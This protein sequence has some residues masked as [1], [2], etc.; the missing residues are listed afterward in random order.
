MDTSVDQL[1]DL[2]PSG[3]LKHVHPSSGTRSTHISL[4]ASTDLGPP[5]NLA[6]TCPHPLSLDEGPQIETDRNHEQV[7]E[8]VIRNFYDIF[9][10][11][12]AQWTSLVFLVLNK[13]KFINCMRN[14]KMHNDILLSRYVQILILFEDILSA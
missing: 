10:R 9:L 4:G 11:P 14:S 13:S 6:P 5:H 2:A 7:W 12:D 1:Q 3:K 8:Q